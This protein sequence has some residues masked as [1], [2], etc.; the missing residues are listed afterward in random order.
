MLE[1]LQSSLGL[2]CLRVSVFGPS[3]RVDRISPVPGG[4]KVGLREE[5][6]KT[7]V[8]GLERRYYRVGRVSRWYGGVGVSRCCGWV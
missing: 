8:R 6:E 5:N 4:S 2:F 1:W 7:V 3:S